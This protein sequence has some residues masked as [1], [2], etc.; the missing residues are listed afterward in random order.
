MESEYPPCLCVLPIKILY[1]TSLQIQAKL[2]PHIQSYPS[3][4]PLS[5]TSNPR[6]AGYADVRYCFSELKTNL[7]FF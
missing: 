2:K 1:M 5:P 3:L 7:E 4:T 6:R